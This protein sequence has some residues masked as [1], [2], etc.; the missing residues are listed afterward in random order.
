MPKHVE[1]KYKVDSFDK[2][3]QKL[4]ELGAKKLNTTESNHY[5]G[6]QDTLDATKLIVYS[7][8]CEI[9]VLKEDNGSFKLINNIP[10]K[11]KKAGITWLK[12]RG[13]DKITHLKM[14]YTEYKY[15]QGIV[16]LYFIND[17]LYSVILDYPIKEQP[18]MCKLFGLE[19]AEVIEKPYNQYLKSMIVSGS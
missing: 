1:K 10:V 15:D 3:L 9:H 12:T 4:N 6:E 17:I 5:Y 8:K 2:I 13:F 14:L 11:D 16:G 18:T 7:E 19:N